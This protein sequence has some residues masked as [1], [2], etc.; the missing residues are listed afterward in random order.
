[1]FFKYS[2]DTIV[3]LAIL[4]FY[5]TFKDLKRKHAPQVKCFLCK[6]LFVENRSL[7][8]QSDTICSLIFKIFIH[9]KS[10]ELLYFQVKMV[11]TATEILYKCLHT[12]CTTHF[13]SYL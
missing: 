2:K 12:Q 11:L 1:M 9:L 6:E 10:L 3:Y 8:L 7:S 5:H 4:W 13:P